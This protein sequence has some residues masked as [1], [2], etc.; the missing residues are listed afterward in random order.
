MPV[1]HPDNP[2]LIFWQLTMVFIIFF[3]FFYIPFKIAFSD[4]GN[5]TSPDDIYWIKN[6]VEFSILVLAIDLFVSFNTGYYDY[7]QLIL[8]RKFIAINY[9]KWAFEL[10][11]LGVI[12]LSVALALN[13]HCDDLCKNTHCTQKYCHY[14]DWIRLLFYFRFYYVYRFNLKVEELL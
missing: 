10:D 9:L 14:I 1:F 13:N 2:I 11:L 4:I 7:G 12:S 6:F 3:Y 8:K 5:D